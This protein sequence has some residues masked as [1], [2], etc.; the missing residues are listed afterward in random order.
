M[1]SALVGGKDAVAPL[2][3]IARVWPRDMTV[4]LWQMRVQSLSCPAAKWEL[5][6]AFRQMLFAKEGQFVTCSVG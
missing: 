6:T 5:D 1:W 3:Q 2:V 4:L